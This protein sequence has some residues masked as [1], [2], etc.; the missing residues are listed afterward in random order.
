MDDYNNKQNGELRGFDEVTNE[1]G[2][3]VTPDGGFYTKS[4]EDIIQ[5]EAFKSPEQPDDAARAEDTPQAEQEARQTYA[6]S[7]ANYSR[8][9][10][11]N[12]GGTTFYAKPPKQKKIKK[13]AFGAGCN[14]GSTG[15]GHRCGQRYSGG[16]AF[17]KKRQQYLS[18]ITSSVSGS[19]VI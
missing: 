18:P 9:N 2:Y 11:Y 14:R 1:N 13:G 12:Y 7:G 5:D 3:T 10:N 15:G 19:N 17:I 6:D 4:R 16:N 8:N